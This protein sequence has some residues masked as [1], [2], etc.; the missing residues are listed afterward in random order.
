MLSDTDKN[1]LHRSDLQISFRVIAVDINTSTFKQIIF[2]TTRVIKSFMATR[3]QKT[4]FSIGV[5]YILFVEILTLLVL[6]CPAHQEHFDKEKQFFADLAAS[7]HS[8]IEQLA[9][10]THAKQQHEQQQQE[11]IPT[12]SFPPNNNQLTQEDYGDGPAGA[13]RL[14]LSV[15][16]GGESSITPLA[17]MIPPMH[18]KLDSLVKG[19]FG[20][21]VPLNFTFD[22][23]NSTVSVP[24]SMVAQN[25]NISDV[26]MYSPMTNFPLEFVSHNMTYNISISAASIPMGIELHPENST[27]PLTLSID[28]NNNIPVTLNVQKLESPLLNYVAFGIMGGLNVLALLM[29][30]IQQFSISKLRRR[31]DAIDVC[32]EVASGKRV[33]VGNAWHRSINGESGRSHHEIDPL[34]SHRN[35]VNEDD[36]SSSSSSSSPTKS[37]SNHCTMCTTCGQVNGKTPFCFNC[38]TKLSSPSLDDSSIN[39]AGIRS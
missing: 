32:N 31:V 19:I 20:E 39:M 36:S 15:G 26:H 29:I 18:P 34:L 2:V 14:P 3:K 9:Q 12:I 27:I 25:L 6:R 21:G 35:I 28:G 33:R 13:S 4:L 1:W 30:V 11:T 23:E 17:E 5:Y 37:L 10:G 16:G 7:I 24:L 38:G 22:F 8:Q